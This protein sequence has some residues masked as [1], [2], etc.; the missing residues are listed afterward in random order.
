ML[1][2]SKAQIF[3]SSI[4][5]TIMPGDQ[6]V[7]L[8]GSLIAVISKGVAETI[9]APEKVWVATLKHQEQITAVD[10]PKLLDEGHYWK[11]TPP[12]S[13]PT[14]GEILEMIR[15]KGP[16]RAYH[17]GNALQIPVWAQYIRADL[18]GKIKSLLSEGKIRKVKGT[19]R[20]PK[21]EIAE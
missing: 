20:L 11:L 8:E 19:G 17:I 2:L 9:K 1:D 5:D 21:Y 18:S 15:I 6:L 4:A 3:T 10:P 16:I 7:V 14:K 13:N 12:P